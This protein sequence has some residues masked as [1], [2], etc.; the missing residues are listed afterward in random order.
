LSSLFFCSTVDSELSFIGNMARLP[1]MDTRLI[2]TYGLA[3]SVIINIWLIGHQD[4]GPVYRLFRAA[5]PSLPLPLPNPM[6]E[7]PHPL[8]IIPFNSTLLFHQV[9]RLN[10]LV[11]GTWKSP[12]LKRVEI[13]RT[14][15]NGDPAIHLHF[16]DAVTPPITQDTALSYLFMHADIC[17]ASRYDLVLIMHSLEHA[18]PFLEGRCQ[19]NAVLYISNMSELP[20]QINPE[21]EKLIK[22]AT[23]WKN[24]RI[25][26]P[27]G[28]SISDGRRSLFENT[29]L[30]ELPLSSK[31]LDANVHIIETSWS[32]LSKSWMELLDSFPRPILLRPESINAQ[33]LK[34]LYEKLKKGESIKVGVIGGSISRGAG[35]SKLTQSYQ[36]CS[37]LDSLAE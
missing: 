34:R 20:L 35:V 5:D 1:R 19:N 3:L 30:H 8:P 24:F 18:R 17:D 31:N 12:S 23:K 13:N 7:S 22:K 21:Y 37:N 15:G 11:I 32:G 33:N 36:L 26:I 16:L 6:V 9:H 25:G 28:F 29:K 10:I 2:V 14:F 4:S 27:S